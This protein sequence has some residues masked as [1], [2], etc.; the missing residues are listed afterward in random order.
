M[1][2][3]EATANDKAVRQCLKAAE[4]GR[5]ATELIRNYKTLSLADM[6]STVSNSLTFISD[7]SKDRNV[8]NLLKKYAAFKTTI[9]AD[10]YWS[11]ILNQTVTP[12]GADAAR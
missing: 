12:E 3:D 11:P 10:P 8:S 4:A 9:E 2:K 7:I 1:R 6:L 5:A